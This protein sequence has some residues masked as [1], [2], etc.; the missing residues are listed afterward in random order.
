MLFHNF[1]Q[2]DL[3][4]DPKHTP[5]DIVKFQLDALQNND[6]TPE[7]TGI[8]ITYA[9]ASPTN[10]RA[11][12]SLDDFILLVKN[13]LYRPLIGFEHAELD[14]IRYAGNL[15]HQHVHVHHRSGEI[16]S[17]VFTLSRQRDGEY[18]G[19]WMTDGV[20]RVG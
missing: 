1:W 11:I 9:F 16:F 19:C 17:Y 4:P 6:L 2:R 13:P 3:Q 15:A 7:N 12:G 5:E 20:L 10:R 8:Q 14:P 18:R